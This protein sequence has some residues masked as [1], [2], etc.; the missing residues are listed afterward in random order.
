[1]DIGFYGVG[2]P[3]LGVDCLVKQISLLLMHYGCDTVVGK[4]MQISMKLFIIKLGMGAQP[5]QVDFMKYG[6]LVSN[7]WLKSIWEKV[8]QFRITITESLANIPR[9]RENDKWIMVAFA[10]NG[11]KLDELIRLNRIRT[12]QQ[13]L[14]ISDVM[15]PSG[16]VVEKKYLAKW[17]PSKKWSIYIFPQQQPPARDFRL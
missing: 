9:L 4:M 15:G 12:H 8:H 1:M 6:E 11:H 2:C 14:F 16:R 17:D 5:F 7:S 13:V 3:H 10:E